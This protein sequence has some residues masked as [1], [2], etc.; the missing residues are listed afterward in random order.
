MSVH[1]VAVSLAGYSAAERLRYDWYGETPLTRHLV[2]VTVGFFVYDV[3]DVL[4]F[5]KWSTEYILHGILCLI[6]FVGGLV[7]GSAAP[8]D[9]FARRSHFSSPPPPP[10]NFPTFSAPSC[11]TSRSSCFYL[12]RRR[13]F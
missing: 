11:T 5:E 1:V 6:L 9:G 13:P 2:N 12:K 4:F 10:P 3:V 8:D 7:R